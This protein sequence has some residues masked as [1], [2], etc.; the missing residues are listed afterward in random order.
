M[1]CF[2]YYSEAKEKVVVHLFLEGEKLC[3]CGARPR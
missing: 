3:I 1:S 2:Y